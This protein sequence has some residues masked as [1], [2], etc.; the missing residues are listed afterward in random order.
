MNNTRIPDG[1]PAGGEFTFHNRSDSDVSLTQISE[2]EDAWLIIE[3]GIPLNTSQY[4]IVDIDAFNNMLEV[5]D[6]VAFRDEADR[7]GLHSIADD[8]E[9]VLD[10]CFSGDGYPERD[11]SERDNITEE[12]RQRPQEYF[13]IEDGLIQNAPAGEVFVLDVL[14]ADLPWND[15]KDDVIDLGR[16]A[17][18]AALKSEDAGVP[19]PG[20][21]NIERRCAD[22]VGANK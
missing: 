16:R 13:V 9:S 4:P 22:L 2:P 21:R 14:T 11:D 5:D 8:A 12:W 15:R 19:A 3:E 7:L 17:T 6:I 10:D 20:L 18:E 1:Q